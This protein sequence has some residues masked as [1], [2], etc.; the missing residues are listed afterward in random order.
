MLHTDIEQ[1]LAHIELQCD[2]MSAAVESGE[3]A[4][5]EAASNALRQASVDF[6]RLLE[7]FPQAVL[8][9]K[10]LTSR[11]KKV[12]ALMAIQ[13]E[14]LIRRTVSVERALHAMVPATRESTYSSASSLYGGATKQSGAFKGL[15]A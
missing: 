8:S 4:A 9:D 14:N 10:E 13:R 6:S 11:V 15:S 12:A 1:P 5:L 2:A 7:T 3:P